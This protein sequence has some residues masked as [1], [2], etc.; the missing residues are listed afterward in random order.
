MKYDLWTKTAACRNDVCKWTSKNTDGHSTK[1]NS[2]KLTTYGTQVKAKKNK[3]CVGY[4][5]IQTNTN[6]VNKTCTLLQTTGGRDEPHIIFMR[7]S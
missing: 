6:N 4:H 2:E 3:T 7:K 5:Y 1:D